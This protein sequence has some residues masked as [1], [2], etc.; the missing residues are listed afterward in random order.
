MTTSRRR[1]SDR[2][3]VS[4]T[5]LMVPIILV[6]TMLIV[7]FG[8]AYYAQTVM[9]G[10]A[11]D[12]A[13]TGARVGGSSGDG[14][15][16]AESLVTQGAAHLL[17]SGAPYASAASDGNVVTVT[18]RGEVVKVFPLFPAISVGAKRSATVERFVVEG[19]P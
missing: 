5:V 3:E 8:L 11:Q 16:L 18:T 17:S 1:A 2:G 6:G 12:G 19:G 9:S 13:A 14:Q 7:Q 15:A 4:V 10:A